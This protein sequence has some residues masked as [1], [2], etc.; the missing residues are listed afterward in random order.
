MSVKWHC[1]KSC[2]DELSHFWFSSLLY[3]CLF[4]SVRVI[5][6]CISVTSNAE[7]RSVSA[8]LFA[9][10][11]GPMV[12]VI[13]T[14][15]CDALLCECCHIFHRRV[16]YH[17]LSLCCVCI[18]SSGIILIP[19]ATFVQNFVSFMAFV[20]VLAHGEKLHT[21]PL[22]QSFSLFNAANFYL[23]FSSI[24]QLTINHL[25]NW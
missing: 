6:L 1:F 21:H 25:C 24:R 5:L 3:F 14:L 10:T 9:G 8:R 23:P 16:W 2:C 17:V 18:R 22:N 7:V 12:S 4:Y 11:W 13:T 15:L 19:Y 20:A